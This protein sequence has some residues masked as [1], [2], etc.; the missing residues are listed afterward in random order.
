L[1]DMRMDKEIDQ[2]DFKIKETEYKT[3]LIEIKAQIDSAKKT[4]PNFYEDGC[5]TLELCNRLHSLYVEANYEEKAKIL[6][7]VAS[8]YTI[9][10]TTITPTYRKPFSLF[11]KRASRP[12]WLPL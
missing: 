10:T 9:N 5:K 4:N 12:N 7:A 3:Q 2:A 11:A 1:F 6:K 8:N